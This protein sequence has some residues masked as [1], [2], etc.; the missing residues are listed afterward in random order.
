MN[1]HTWLS[2]DLPEITTPSPLL[3]IRWRAQV[4]KSGWGWS[5]THQCAARDH[6]EEFGYLTQ[7]IALTSAC[8]HMR[9]H[10]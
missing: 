1:D 7:A 4:F 8:E 9:E 3:D 6:A 2:H 5:W 10:G